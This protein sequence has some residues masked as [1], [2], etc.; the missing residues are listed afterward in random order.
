M[1]F[2]MTA[3]TAFA[4]YHLLVGALILLALVVAFKYLR[5]SAESQNWLWITAFIIVGILPFT[6]FMQGPSP[7]DVVPVEIQTSIPTNVENSID[8]NTDQANQVPPTPMNGV[9]SSE[10]I[11]LS[12]SNEWAY[13]LAPWFVFAL[14]IWAAGCLWR[15]INI[16]Q[17]WRKTR[18]LIKASQPIASL[19]IDRA[20]GLNELDC[21]VRV[22]AITHSPL[23]AGLIKP[24]I[25]LPA[26]LLKRLNLE[27]L[28]PII[29]HEWAHIRRRDLW[30]VMLQEA[31]AIVFWW[32]P[33]MRLFNRK[34]Y[35]T[36]EL[37]CDMRAARDLA[38]P[39]QYAQ[40]LL[41]CARLMVTRRH[42]VLAMGMFRKKQD[43]NQRVDH[44]MKMQSGKVYN[45]VL[46]VVACFM[47]VAAGL[48]VAT[49][50]DKKIIIAKQANIDSPSAKEAFE[51]AQRVAAGNDAVL[52]KM[53]R[54]SAEHLK[55]EI[56]KEERDVREVMNR[57]AA[58]TNGFSIE[59]LHCM[60]NACEVQL[61]FLDRDS[62]NMPKQVSTLM[63]RLPW[64]NID[65]HRMVTT[66]GTAV[67]S[68]YRY[69]DASI[70]KV[71]ESGDVQSLEKLL[72]NGFDINTSIPSDGTLL[73]MAVNEGRSDF[74]EYLLSNGADVNQSSQGDGNP[75]IAASKKGDV[76]VADVLYQYGAEVNVL[77]G[78]DE[79][80]L[81]NAA[82]S[83]SLAMVKFLVER[84]ADVNLSAEV[85][86][87]HGEIEY[88]S[89]INQARTQEIERYLASMGAQK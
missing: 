13:W 5:F 86:N 25:V 41:E 39:K 6:L 50:V 48:V 34:I 67:I 24:V 88:R 84:G 32:S 10:R 7:R 83:G 3:L 22:S 16:V 14:C 47:L 36:R 38:N 58:E 27:Q 81:I 31:I 52:I 45:S 49:E 17:S 2:L 60:V 75:L 33:V 56:Y 46:S 70:K 73:I 55:Y 61:K 20:T 63:R 40:C 72:V 28:R 9:V 87:L 8:L 77:V 19:P 21:E 29:L 80:P 11:N 85:K 68:I 79:T 12:I 51:R 4:I 54:E 42:D 62:G 76:K 37:A 35:I 23:V 64:K 43:L 78:G 69:Q 59:S 30:T 53:N 44:V 65:L 26:D 71:I 1:D 57:I 18:Q 74:V 82:R 89:P 66:D 15:A